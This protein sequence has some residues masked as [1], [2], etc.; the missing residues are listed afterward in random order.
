MIFDAKHLKKRGYIKKKEDLNVA[1]GAFIS[2]QSRHFLLWTLLDLLT[3]HSFYN[4]SANKLLLGLY[5]VLY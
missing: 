5:I 1:H 2:G 3:L 4:S